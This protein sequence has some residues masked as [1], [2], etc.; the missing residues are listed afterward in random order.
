MSVIVP[1]SIIGISGSLFLG[2]L[3]LSR[4]PR[5]NT[6]HIFL[7]IFFFLLALRLGK[8]LVQEYGSTTILNLYFNIM[9]ASFLA[10]GPSLWYYIRAYVSDFTF[11]KQGHSVHFLPSL[12]FL[13]AA[14]Q[15]R[16]FVGEQVWIIIYW[17]IQLHP[18]LY[19]LGSLQYLIKNANF[20]NETLNDKIWI[21]SLLATTLSVVVMN[22]LYF[23][24]NFPFYLVIALLLIFTVYLFTYLA[25]HDFTKV[26]SGRTRTKYKNLNLDAHKTNLL[27]SKIDSTIHEKKLYLNNQL[28]LADVAEMI[29]IPSHVISSVINQSYQVSFPKY[30]NLLR[31]KEAQQRLIEEY[32]KKIIAI[33]LES[34]FYSLSAFNRVFKEHTGMNPSH[35]R[36]KFSQERSPDL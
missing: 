32:D 12:V 16:L 33:A 24:F 6:S 15:I 13:L 7:S 23:T 34:G 17:I 31:I 11:K 20:K 14:Y 36:S 27:K 1:F 35:Y 28:K 8:I 10:I 25:F 2:I 29:N 21:C 22:I 18:I 26:V 3:L 5:N 9:H 19:V 30:I 4:R